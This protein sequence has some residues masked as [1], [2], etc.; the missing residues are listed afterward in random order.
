MRTN[1][2]FKVEIE[3]EASEKPEKLGSEIRRQLLKMYAVREVELAGVTA[4]E[5]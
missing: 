1:L 5:D 4:A 3:H 2:Y